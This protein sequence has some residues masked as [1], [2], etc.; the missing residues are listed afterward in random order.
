MAERRIHYRSDSQRKH[1]YGCQNAEFTIDPSENANLECQS[2]EFTI[3]SQRNSE[4]GVPEHRIHY[5]P[6]Q[7]CEFRVP[8]RGLKCRIHLGNAAGMRISSASKGLKCR[9]HLGNAAG[10]RIS[11]ASKGLEMQNAL[12]KRSGN[13]NFE[14]QQGA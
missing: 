4:S 11:S 12:G 14:C 13:A 8:A 6:L 9:M 5:K 10:M 1:D 3:D 7:Q 2:A